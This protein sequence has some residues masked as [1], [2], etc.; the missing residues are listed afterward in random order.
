L[1]LHSQ[2]QGDPDRIIISQILQAFFYP[3]ESIFDNLFRQVL[4]GRGPGQELRF[5]ALIKEVKEGAADYRHRQQDG[6]Y[7]AGPQV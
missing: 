4:F 1:G 2:H 7:Q 3:L 5:N 6:G